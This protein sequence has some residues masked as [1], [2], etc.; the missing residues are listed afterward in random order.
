VTSLK[1]L[2]RWI[3]LDAALRT[4]MLDIDKFARKFRVT[5][6]TIRR[7]ISA[8]QELGQVMV[9]EKHGRTYWWRYDAFIRPLFLVNFH[10]RP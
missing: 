4:G 3:A 5:E 8:F 9:Y 10:R 1:I 6:K 2:K 7:D